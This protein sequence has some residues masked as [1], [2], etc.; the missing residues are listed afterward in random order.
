MGKKTY[1]T[2]TISCIVLFGC[3][4]TDI[5]ND[6]IDS[7]L[8]QELVKF[9][10]DIERDLQEDFVKYRISSMTTSSTLVDIFIDNID[11]C[12]TICIFDTNAPC[13]IGMKPKFEFKNCLSVTD[14]EKNIYIF[15]MF[16]LG[17]LYD[18]EKM[19]NIGKTKIFFSDG[20]FRQYYY[21]AGK[22][23]N[24]SVQKQ[25]DDKIVVDL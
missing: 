3:H 22:L 15:D 4:N 17:I 1:L 18:K 16:D 11:T 12:V 9:R 24:F 7:N 6:V 13:N 5:A 8:Q 14:G 2:L 25:S 21:R 19:S 10:S 20:I 23:V